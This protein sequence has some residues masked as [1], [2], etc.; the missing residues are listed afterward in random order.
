[1]AKYFTSSNFKTWSGAEWA[2]VGLVIFSLLILLILIVTAAVMSKKM[3]KDKEEIL[4]LRN[5]LPEF[6]T[7]PGRAESFPIRNW[8]NLTSS[9]PIYD[10][11]SQGYDPINNPYPY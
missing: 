1:M 8:N 3:K 9:E 10:Q 2:I 11:Q 5:E 7:R 6:M 4:R